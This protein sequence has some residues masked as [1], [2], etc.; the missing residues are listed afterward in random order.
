MPQVRGLST[1]CVPQ[2]AR[3][4]VQTTRIE[5]SGQA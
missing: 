2:H 1:A 3:S 5:S 4:S